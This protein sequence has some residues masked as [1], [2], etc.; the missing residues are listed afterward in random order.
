VTE[1]RNVTGLPVHSFTVVY[2]PNPLAPPHTAEAAEELEP[3]GYL[4][5]FRRPNGTLF[6]VSEWDVLSVDGVVQ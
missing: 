5:V 2:R 4:R 1:Q 6:H 3:V